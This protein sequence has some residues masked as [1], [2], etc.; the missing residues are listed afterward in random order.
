MVKKK[1]TRGADAA[2]EHEVAM[3]PEP[4]E[5]LLKQRE[6]F[7]QKFGRKPGLTEAVFFDPS[8]GE[9]QTRRSPRAHS[10]R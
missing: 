6:A 4:R 9:P 7:I 1:R 5:L 2:G 10:R 3:S 8:A